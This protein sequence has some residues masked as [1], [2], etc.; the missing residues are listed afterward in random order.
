MAPIASVGDE[1]YK[2]PKVPEELWAKLNPQQRIFTE[3]LLG[4]QNFDPVVAAREAGY[5]VPASS[6]ALLMKNKN[7]LSLIGFKMS[8]RLSKYRISADRVV[9][10]LAHIGLFN[11]KSLLDAQGN[12]RQLKDMP[13]EV[14]VAIQSMKVTSRKDKDGNETECTVDLKFWNKLEALTLLCK[15]LGILQ[16]HAPVNVNVFNW[17]KLAQTIPPVDTVEQEIARLSQPTGGTVNV[18]GLSGELVPEG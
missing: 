6:A 17:D 14:S 4:D 13:D 18:D 1:G 16:D 10:E 15:H 12:V 8:Q 2:S 3:A 9:Q 7:I 11:M 5:K